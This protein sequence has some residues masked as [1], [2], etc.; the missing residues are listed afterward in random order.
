ML[1]I[2]AAQQQAFDG[3]V[4]TN[5]P[6]LTPAN[7]RQFA[8]KPIFVDD[9]SAGPDEHRIFD[10]VKRAFG[11]PVVP[12]DIRALARWP[13]FLVAYWQVLQPLF[14]SPIY[15]ECQYGIRESAWNLAR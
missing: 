7:P 6:P 5:A 3:N 2:V 9:T 12:N 13:G 15:Q 11:V 10:E 4:G 14:A 8:R 1:L